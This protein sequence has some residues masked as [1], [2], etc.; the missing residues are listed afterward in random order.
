MVIK[1]KNKEKKTQATTRG[2][3]FVVV[4]IDQQK[5]HINKILL[6]DINIKNS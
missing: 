3:W 2:C 6:R 5:Y 1:L 4:Q